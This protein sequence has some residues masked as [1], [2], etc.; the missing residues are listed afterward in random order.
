M[1]NITGRIF[2]LGRLALLASQ[3]GINVT[4]HNISNV[5]TPGYSRQ[6]LVLET[7]QPI[8]T[9]Y[10]QVGTGVRAETIERVHDRFLARQINDAQK[11][12]GMWEARKEVLTQV[13]FVFNESTGIGL[14][15][16]MESFWNAWQDVSNNPS[17]LTEREVLLTKADTMSRD[18]NSVY[19]R[20]NQIQADTRGLID[21]TID[22]INRIARE[23][24]DLNSRI[25]RIEAGGQ[26]ANDLQDQRDERL[27]ELASLIDINTAQGDGGLLYVAAAQYPLVVG[28]AQPEPL[29]LAD[30]ED[31]L[32]GGKLKGYLDAFNEVNAYKENVQLL[33]HSIR[34]RVNGQHKLGY[35]L[36]GESANPAVNT[37]AGWFF[38]PDAEVL[39]LEISDYKRVAAASLPDAEGDNANAIAIYGLRDQ[40]MGPEVSSVNVSGTGDISPD[41][42]NFT[43]SWDNDALKWTILRGDTAHND[44]FT[45][46][47]AL[48]AD[49]P[50]FVK[51]NF[52]LNND[53]VQD[54][55]VEITLTDPLNYNAELAF[56][57]LGG[58]IVYKQDQTP[59]DFYNGLVA[60]IGNDVE[61]TERNVTHS[62]E[63]ATQLD[64]YRESISGVNMDEEM[65]NLIQ[66]QNAYQAAAKIISTVDEMLDTLMNMI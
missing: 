48:P 43:V 56:D 49:Q 23:I 63:M 9:T 3:Q 28:M 20:L 21:E 57:I 11:P 55:S 18:F 7:N 37:N 52:D 62:T 42:T 12:L 30:V 29:T 46:T 45:A 24:T 22:D 31:T 34:D 39:D 36:F 17:G 25:N 53:G 16:S 13:E 4:G 59:H 64:N 5:N 65:V 8:D 38:N 19:T 66:F 40:S 33:A 15:E 6:R 1:A 54:K 44:P 27:K 2:D 26:N 10:G 58:D 14:N 61:N 32:T 47:L 60:G 41:F 51:I 35:D 50:G